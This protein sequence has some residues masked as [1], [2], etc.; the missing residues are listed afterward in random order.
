MARTVRA[1]IPDR[2]M[3]IPS[4][5]PIAT[6][7]ILGL[8]VAVFVL[9]SVSPQL[10][11]WFTNHGSLLRK[12]MLIGEWWRL[13]TATFLHD[14]IV[15]IA[16]N[17]FSLYMIGI[18]VE[19]LFGRAQFIAIYAISGLAG[20]VAFF[21]FEEAPGLGASGAIFGV[22]GALVVYYA[23]NRSLFG[24]FG[25][26]NFNVILIVLVGN[27][28]FGYLINTTGIASVGNEAHIGGLIAGAAVGFVLC[29]RYILGKWR[30][31]I[32]REIEN[33]NTGPLPWVA[34]ILIAL[35]TIG[36][37]IDGLIYFR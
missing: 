19:A 14:G 29:P 26:K 9:G 34:T 20:S 22:F 8:L 13:I 2:W 33:I 27:I 4:E 37:Y 15:H 5:K 7:I 16:L 21:L 31:P 17:G 25:R 36:I 23:L 28:A 12:P 32:V 18:E 10:N 6:Q 1:T 35:I 30:N 3:R 11:I 24:A